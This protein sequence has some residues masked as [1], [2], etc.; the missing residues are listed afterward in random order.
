MLLRKFLIVVVGSCYLHFPIVLAAENEELLGKALFQVGMAEHL[1]HSILS[2]DCKQFLTP[3]VLGWY[4]TRDYVQL[5]VEL[6][7]KLSKSAHI[8]YRSFVSSQEYQGR[9]REAERTYVLGRLTDL[10]RSGA[11]LAFSCGFAFSKVS[12]SMARAEMSVNDLSLIHISE[13]T[14]P[15]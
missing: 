4:G 7:A 14:R 9:L 12:E 2:T 13:P 15:Y 3:E 1:R 11:P 8:E 10:K 6:T 5:K